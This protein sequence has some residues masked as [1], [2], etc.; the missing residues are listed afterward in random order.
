MLNLLMA[1]VLICTGQGN[2]YPKTNIEL[3]VRPAGENSF[4]RYEFAEGSLQGTA[5][6]QAIGEMKRKKTGRT[7]TYRTGTNEGSTVL[8]LTVE[9]AR[10]H[11][12]QLTHY[13]SNLSEAPVECSFQ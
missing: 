12:A 7:W 6:I 13:I 11:S 5:Y 10:I 3:E 2:T 8:V 1:S 4:L 9:G